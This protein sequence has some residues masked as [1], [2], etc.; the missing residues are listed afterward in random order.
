[1]RIIGITGGIGSGKS[2]VSG[3]LESLGVKIIDADVIARDIVKK[4]RIA[5]NEIERQFGKSVI[6][7]T[8]E[9][10]R[11]KLADIVFENT[12]KL[13]VLNQITHKYIKDKID[14]EINQAKDNG[15]NCVV[16]DAAIL[17]ENGFIDL[18]DEIWVVYACIEIRTKRIMDR[19]GFSYEEAIKRINAQKDE[20]E[21][22]KHADE[23]ILN[24]S[25]FKELREHVLESYGKKKIR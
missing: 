20:N 12:E 15:I 5:L 21:Y 25:G 1:M 10:D 2:T 7:N 24:E 16:I 17:L 19:N 9:L 22:L 4:G 23:V 13:M 18:V 8:G 6:D 3:I 11:K 14:C